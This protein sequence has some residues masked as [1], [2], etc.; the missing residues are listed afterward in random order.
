M[1]LSPVQAEEFYQECMEYPHPL[2]DQFSKKYFCSCAST[3]FYK[4]FSPRQAEYLKFPN[5]ERG[6]YAH[7]QLVMQVY[8]PC[9]DTPVA[10]FM[11]YECTGTSYL[12]KVE[13]IDKSTYCAC[14]RYRIPMLLKE[15]PR[16]LR[17][18]LRTTE[19]VIEDPITSYLTNEF[20]VRNTN[21]I[22]QICFDY[23]KKEPA[24]PLISRQPRQ[25]AQSTS[26]RLPTIAPLLAG[27]QTSPHGGQPYGLE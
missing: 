25:G 21:E 27:P 24:K 20:F 23:A 19:G 3:N 1:G 22:S 18:E 9:M 17:N 7:K 4:R 11:Y 16:I 15:T 12:D 5:S 14:Q 10:D 26:R 13:G 6:Q 2:K 8:S